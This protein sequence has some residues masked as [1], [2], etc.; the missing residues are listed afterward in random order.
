[1]ALF[2]QPD[3]QNILWEMV[4]RIPLCNTVFPISGNGSQ[5]KEQ[6]FREIIQECYYSI[7]QNITRNELYKINR[8]VLSRMMKSLVSL[9]SINTANIIEGGGNNRLVNRGELNKQQTDFVSQ[10]N[11]MFEIKKPKPIDFSEKID[12][13]VITNMSELIENQRK[14]RELEIQEFSS[15][16]KPIDSLQNNKIN[17]NILEDVPIQSQIISVDKIQSVDKKHVRFD[18][19]ENESKEVSTKDFKELSRKIENLDD[20]IT[21]IF[22]ILQN[23]ILDK[24][25]VLDNKQ[26]NNDNLNNDNLNNDNLNN[27]NL[28]NNNNVN[29]EKIKQMIIDNDNNDV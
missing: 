1:M 24:S 9:S 23:I 19:L 6:W 21:S 10:Y 5:V 20:K 4:N 11:S 12:D 22:N 17:I 18:L 14:M 26:S 28:N 15:V 29:I 7:P 2:I 13:D 8:D 3:N 16:I 27:D 25:N